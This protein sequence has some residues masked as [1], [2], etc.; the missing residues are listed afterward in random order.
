MNKNTIDNIIMS[1]QS[2]S[3]TIKNLEETTATIDQFIGTEQSRLSSILYNVE[4]ITRNLEQNNGEITRMISNIATLSDSLAKADMVSVINNADK[5][6]TELNHL[7]EGVNRGQGTIGQLMQND[8]LYYQLESSAEQLN[9]LLED[10][11]LNPKRYVKISV[12]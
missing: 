6:L 3:K 11:R 5:S 4:L 8:S 1:F 9:K 2:V 10:V 7:L 12:F